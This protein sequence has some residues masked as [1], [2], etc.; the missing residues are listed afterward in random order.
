MTRRAE[1]AAIRQR[2]RESLSC[3]FCHCG[4]DGMKC[5]DCVETYT[6]DD[7]NPGSEIERGNANETIRGK[8]N[9]PDAGDA[10]GSR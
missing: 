5:P 1:V 6:F 4:L 3:Y 9:N 7:P 8:A 2:V 10:T